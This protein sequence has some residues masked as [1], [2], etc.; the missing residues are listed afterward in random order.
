MP[1]D[2]ESHVRDVLA[3]CIEHISPLSE[4]TAEYIN[5]KIFTLLL[6]V[7]EI[8]DCRTILATGFVFGILHHPRVIERGSE[9]VLNVI[10]NQRVQNIDDTEEFKSLESFIRHEFDSNFINCELA[11]NPGLAIQSIIRFWSNLKSYKISEYFCTELSKIF[12]EK[13]IIT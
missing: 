13:N 10:K 7:T 5:E 8:D 1:N 6:P 11:G 2:W 3:T 9:F 12:A 4:E